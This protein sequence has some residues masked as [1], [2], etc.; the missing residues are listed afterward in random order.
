MSKSQR[1]TKG[2][3]RQDKCLHDTVRYNVTKKFLKEAIDRASMEY[4]LDRKAVQSSLKLSKL[5]NFHEL[6]GKT[7]SL[8]SIVM[9]KK[10]RT[11]G[12]IIERIFGD[13]NE[14]KKCVR[15]ITASKYNKG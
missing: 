7:A 3:E 4:G 6:I 14:I 12:E 5:K 1:K 11:Y 10:E 2:E 13:K 8:I 9:E 15:K